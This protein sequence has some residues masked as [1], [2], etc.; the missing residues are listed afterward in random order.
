LAGD[1]EEWLTFF[2]QGVEATS[3]QA[4]ATARRILTLLDRD[5]TRC[6]SV[7][8]SAGTVTRVHHFMRQNPVFTLASVTEAV[9][10]SFP[11]ASAAVRTLESLG[12]V[13]ELTGRGRDR[14]YSYSEYIGIL[15]EGTELVIEP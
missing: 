2:L 6:E 1:W 15:N 4:A 13:R 10:I 11:T 8:R 9:K 12:I 5:R 7:G 14:I 3:V